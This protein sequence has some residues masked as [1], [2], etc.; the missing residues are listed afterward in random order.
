M[1]HWKIWGQHVA[2]AAAY[3]A[4]YRIA[5]ALSLAHWELTVGFRLCCLLLVP[6]RLWPALALGEFL[7]VLE[8]ALACIDD[9]GPA[10]AL[11][12]AVPQIVVCMAGMKPLR[13]W[14]ALRDPDGR[15]CMGYV[16]TATL[17][18]AALSTVRDT[19]SLWIALMALSTDGSPGPLLW[20]GFSAYML[21]G[22]LGGLTLV[23]TLLALQDRWRVTPSVWAV[24]RSPLVRDTCMGVAPVLVALTWLANTSETSGAQQLARLAMILPMVAMAWR[25]GWRGTAMAGTGASIALALTSH[26]VRDPAVIHCQVVLAF[27]MSAGLLVGGKRQ[28]AAHPLLRER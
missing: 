9:F 22:Y 7:P 1:E 21:G 10:W 4:F 24:L 12:A 20:V 28:P 27:V 15:L 13:R 16:V 11:A 2:V 25:Y 23:P 8:N 14:G 5:Y 18:C 19:A 17:C 26:V 6:M 3:A